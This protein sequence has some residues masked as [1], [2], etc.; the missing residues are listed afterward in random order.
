[1]MVWFQKGAWLVVH[2][3]TSFVFMMQPAFLQWVIS[4]GLLEPSKGSTWA[5]LLLTVGM[6]VRVASVE[7]LIISDG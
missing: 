7:K 2:L 3:M 5:N 1:M 4:S 6:A